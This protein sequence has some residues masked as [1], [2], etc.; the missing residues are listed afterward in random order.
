MAKAKRKP[1]LPKSGKGTQLTKSKRKKQDGESF[2]VP[3]VLSTPGTDLLVEYMIKKGI[4]LTRE[5]YL[6]MAYPEG[7]PDPMPAELEAML[8]EIFQKNDDTE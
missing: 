3:V 5:N 4:H 6:D 2:E 7:A 1:I 8:P